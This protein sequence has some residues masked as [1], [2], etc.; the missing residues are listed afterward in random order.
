MKNLKINNKLLLRIKALG[1]GLALMTTPLALTGCNNNEKKESLY[2][3]IENNKDNTYIDEI[4]K[5]ENLQELESDMYH[6]DEA[7]TFLKETDKL[8]LSDKLFVIPEETIEEYK[9][10]S[11]EERN[12]LIKEYINT[13]NKLKKDKKNTSLSEQLK[14]LERRII[15]IRT[16]DANFINDNDNNIL[17]ELNKLALKTEGLESNNKPEDYKYVTVSVNYKPNKNIDDDNYLEYNGNKY[18]YTQ[19]KGATKV[20][21]NSLRE[22]LREDNNNN[23][24]FLSEKR[25]NKD[26]KTLNA[27][28]ELIEN[29]N[30][31][32]IEKKSILEELFDDSD[33]KY[34]IKARK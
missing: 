32:K 27:I 19:T 4:I 20:I 25:V 8:G 12:E 1:L 13:K 33:V 17:V 34:K 30:S 24:N 29:K 2:A 21:R 23:S 5:N 16:L 26:I 7:L 10:L 11:S 15:N 31:W 14:S 22:L 9:Y 6:L 28:K 18:S 3:T